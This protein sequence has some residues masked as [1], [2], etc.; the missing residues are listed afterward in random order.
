M[1]KQTAFLIDSG[2]L[3]V[4]DGKCKELGISRSAFLIILIRTGNITSSYMVKEGSITDSYM[5]EKEDKGKYA[6]NG[7]AR[8]EWKGDGIVGIPEV[9]EIGYDENGD[10]V[11]SRAEL[12]LKE[13]VAMSSN[14]LY[15]EAKEIFAG[16]YNCSVTSL[17]KP[18]LDLIKKNA[19][20][21]VDG[22]YKLPDEKVSY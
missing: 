5:G 9:G 12:G 3:A 6:T 4:L 8:E 16:K 18:Q 7:K 10:R 14:E 22:S 20:G 19:R 13:I 11:V 1:K 17:M 21:I 2:D 15:E